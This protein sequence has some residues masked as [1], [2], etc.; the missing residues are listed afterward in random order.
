M[1]LFQ[2]SEKPMGPQPLISTG[3]GRDSV[4][5]KHTAI[6]MALSLG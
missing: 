6:S 1:C 3:I 2:N 5:A 4:L